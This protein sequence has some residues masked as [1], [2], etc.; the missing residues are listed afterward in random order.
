MPGTHLSWG[1]PKIHAETGEK[2]AFLPDLITSMAKLGA[3]FVLEEGY[4]SS[5]GYSELAYRKITDGAVR[6][7]TLDEVLSQPYVMV[8][9]CPDETEISQ[10][11]PGS[12]LVSMLHYPTRPRRIDLMREKKLEGLSLDSI[13]DDSGR[14]LVENLHA[15]AWNGMEVAFKVLQDLRPD[16]TDPRRG[17]IRVTLLGAGAVGIQ[18]V[19][20]A[21]HYANEALRSRLYKQG[22]PGVIVQT[23]DYDITGFSQVMQELLANTDILVDA[24]Q[25]PDPSRPV[26]PNQW[27]SFCPQHTI[28]VDLSV[29]P[30]AI[31]QTPPSVKGIEG[32]PHGNLDQ[33]IF[34]PDDPA[35]D[36]IPDWIDTRQRRWAVS[37][38]SWPGLYPQECM[39]IYGRQLKPIL[40]R[41]VELGG[42]EKVRPNGRF[43]ERAISRGLLSRWE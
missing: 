11:S 17:P 23:V 42:L 7:G 3:R 13:K 35:Y 37:C 5:M 22:V 25:R 36:Q 29:D 27:I 39:Q 21:T 6:F 33:Y 12:C 28:L 10:M 4:G 32:I 41:L 34:A 38:Y 15:V 20:A 30:Y 14:R 9:R 1:L 2:R 31:D 19:Q 16:F 26:I 24:T 8:L 18:V 43:F 40:T